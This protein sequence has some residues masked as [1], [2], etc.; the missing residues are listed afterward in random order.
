[1]AAIS[2]RKVRHPDCAGLMRRKQASDSFNR[3]CGL[4]PHRRHDGRQQRFQPR[5]EWTQGLRL[6]SGDADGFIALAQQGRFMSREAITFVQ[7]EHTRDGLKIKGAQNR[8]HCGDLRV[9]IPGVSVDQMKQDIGVSEFF[10]CRTKCP[11][12]SFGRSR[13]KPTVSVTMISRS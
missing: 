8:F 5:N 3:R 6:K 1:M 11:S 12:R 10:Q 2:D 9:D 7:H 4:R 13:I